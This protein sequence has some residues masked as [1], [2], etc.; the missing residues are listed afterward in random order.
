MPMPMPI[1]TSR[2]D[3]QASVW[4]K[5]AQ[6][7]PRKKAKVSMVW[8]MC[9]SLYEAIEKRVDLA[10]SP[11]QGSVPFLSETENRFL[12]FER[13][14]IET[15]I[16]SFISPLSKCKMREQVRHANSK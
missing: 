3:Q 14:S 9:A 15:G 1:L 12:N 16:S 5:E 4:L 10:S 8:S 2:I 11:P 6:R 7:K 13:V